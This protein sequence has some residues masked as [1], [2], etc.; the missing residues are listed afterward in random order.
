MQN[1]YY[2]NQQSKEALD[3]VN[4]ATQAALQ[5]S[6]NVFEKQ[7]ELLKENANQNLEWARSVGQLT[8]PEEVLNFNRDFGKSELARMRDIGEAHYRL[9]DATGNEMAAIA[10]KGRRLVEKAFDDAARNSAG[11]FPADQTGFSEVARDATKTFN[12]FV[13]ASFGWTMQAVRSGMETALQGQ[14][15]VVNG[16]QQATV[17]GKAHQPAKD[18]R[19]SAKH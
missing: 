15:Q 14:Q 4:E 5:Y 2:N 16:V 7:V 6:V 9:A 1:P 8:T 10:G 12:D 11:V 19:R 17:N 13:Q 3:I 18:K